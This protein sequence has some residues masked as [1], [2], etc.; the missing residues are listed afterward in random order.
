MGAVQEIVAKNPAVESS[1]RRPIPL[2]KSLGFPPRAEAYYQLQRKQQ[3]PGIGPLV[4]EEVLDL[5]P[6]L[7][8]VILHLMPPDRIDMHI[9]APS[10]LIP[11]DEREVELREAAFEQILN[12]T[13]HSK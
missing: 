1:Q 8:H 6:G 2:A 5:E 3:P 12:P 10:S 9:A 4:A 11:F 7:V 13:P